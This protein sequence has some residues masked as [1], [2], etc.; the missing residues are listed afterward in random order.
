M[1]YTVEWTQPAEDELI[2]L[3]MAAPD[4]SLMTTAVHRL[5]QRLQFNPY[6]GRAHQ[7]SVNRV[8]LSS[9]I[10]IWFD[11]IE[12][13]RKVLVLSVWPIG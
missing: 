6:V 3:W 11:I 9:P 5:E 10:G 4:Q 8:V 2:A 7:S 1:N 12:D 13:D